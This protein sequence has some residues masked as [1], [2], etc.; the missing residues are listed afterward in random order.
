MTRGVLGLIRLYQ[1]VVSPYWPGTCR[2]L[3]TCSE[4]A[5]EAV[6]GLGP[7][8]GGW[9][10]LR[11]L[12]RCHPMGGSGYDPVPLPH[13]LSEIDGG[14]LAPATADVSGGIPKNH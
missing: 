10:A 1:R 5:R 12:L 8:V 13:D 2:Y 11:R 9:L 7:W 6:E 4:Y 14:D 3:P